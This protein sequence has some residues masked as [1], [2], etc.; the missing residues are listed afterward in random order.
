MQE[1]IAVARWAQILIGIKRL[2]TRSNLYIYGKWGSICIKCCLKG[3][4]IIRTEGHVEYVSCRTETKVKF[5]LKVRKVNSS[6]RARGS[7]TQIPQTIHLQTLHCSYITNANVVPSL[8]L[9]S[10]ASV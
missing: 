6:R 8:F 7:I 9:E 3:M 2:V 4:N 10:R 1:T 5:P